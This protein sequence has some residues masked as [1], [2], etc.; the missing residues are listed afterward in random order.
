MFDSTQDFSTRQAPAEKQDL[1]LAD[2]IIAIVGNASSLQESF[3]KLFQA[4][5]QEIGCLIQSWHLTKVVDD[6]QIKNTVTDFI[7]DLS[8]SP[9]ESR[10]IARLLAMILQRPPEMR[11]H[12]Q[13]YSSRRLFTLLKKNASA[14]SQA[15][16]T[17]NEMVKKQL[18]ALADE[19]RI[20]H[21]TTGH[22]TAGT[23]THTADADFFSPSVLDRIQ[24]K[25]SANK[26]GINSASLKQAIL[27]LLSDPE[28]IFYSFKTAV[29]STTLFNLT[30]TSS[31]LVS[32]GYQNEPVDREPPPHKRH[33]IKAAAGS[34]LEQVSLQ[35]DESQRLP[36]LMAGLA[37]CFIACPV[38]FTSDDFMAEHQRILTS[39]SGMIDRIHEFLNTE[40]FRDL[41]NKEPGRST[42]FNRIR[43][44]KTILEAALTDF[45]VEAQ[46]AGIKSLVNFMICQYSLLVGRKP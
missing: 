18:N 26:G 43:S 22:W 45:P 3:V 32:F 31:F 34:I 11:Q 33:E 19:G 2:S 23:T 21:L 9:D 1:S 4:I 35:L 6:E 27:D 12:V 28:H 10:F 20:R 36:V 5:E 39:S 7:E 15:Y 37:Y 30:T 29:L 41:F 40:Q 14:S 38:Y 46:Q 24:L 16:L 13:Y 42:V 44:F 17:F 25:S 8:A